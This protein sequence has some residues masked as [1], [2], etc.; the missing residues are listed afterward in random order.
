M[1]AESVFPLPSN[2]DLDIGALVEP[3]AVGWHAVDASPIA[4]IKDPKCIVSIEAKAH[5]QLF[6]RLVLTIFRLPG[7]WRWTNWTRSRSS[8]FSA[9]CQKPSSAWR[10][11]PNASSLRRIS[12][13]IM[14]LIHQSMISS[15]RPWSSAAEKVARIS[16][17]IVPVYQPRLNRLVRS[18]S[19]EEQS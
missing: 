16:H 5:T 6:A 7:L 12:A 8:S 18:S 14:F 11:L 10:W 19:H 17:L 1:P 9:R 4:D 2:V 3:L 13:L 15:K